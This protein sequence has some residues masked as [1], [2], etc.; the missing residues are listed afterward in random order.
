MRQMCLDDGSRNLLRLLDGLCTGDAVGVVKSLRAMSSSADL[1]PSITPIHNRM[2]LAWY[3]S[4]G[5]DGAAIGRALGAK[6]Y[7]WRMASQAARRYGRAA[8]TDFISDLLRISIEER[9]GRGAG[10]NGLETAV[11]KLLARG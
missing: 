9:S 3:A 10:W 11:I 2:R 6:D 8:L 7:A 4:L 1:I 5:N